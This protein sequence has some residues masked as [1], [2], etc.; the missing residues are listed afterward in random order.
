MYINKNEIIK[1][2]SVGR[3]MIVEYGKYNDID[4]W[5]QLVHAVHPNFPGLGTLESINE[6]KCTV[7]FPLCYE[8]TDFGT[9]AP[10][11]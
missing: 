3:N 4:S 9:T 6:H 2:E 10:S 5:M 11:I 7:S 8:I 1:S